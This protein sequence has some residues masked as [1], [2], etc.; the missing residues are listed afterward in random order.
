M[1]ASEQAEGFSMMGAANAYSLVKQGLLV[2]AMGEVPPQ[3][4]EKIAQSTESVDTD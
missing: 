4:V 2:T 1:A 3:T